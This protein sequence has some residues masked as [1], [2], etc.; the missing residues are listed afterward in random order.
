VARVDGKLEL[1]GLGSQA[2]AWEP[3]LMIAL[4]MFTVSG[5]VNNG[6]Q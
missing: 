6:S 4:M 5:R 3:A 2:G 1:P